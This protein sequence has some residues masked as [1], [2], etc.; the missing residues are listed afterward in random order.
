MR[1]RRE[2]STYTDLFLC[3]L[4]SDN[5]SLS[6]IKGLDKCESERFYQ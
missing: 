6:R 4:R 2:D 3:V 5:K 1:N